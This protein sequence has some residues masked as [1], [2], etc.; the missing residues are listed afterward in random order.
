MLWISGLPIAKCDPL[1]GRAIQHDHSGTKPNLV[2][3]FWLP[4]LV[5]TGQRLPKLVTNISSQFHRLVNTGLAVGP[6]VEWLQTKVSN[7]YKIDKFE[8]FIAHRLEMAPSNCNH[9]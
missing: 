8:W 5:T 4:K 9:L 2:A 7:L 1:H 3:K 6:L